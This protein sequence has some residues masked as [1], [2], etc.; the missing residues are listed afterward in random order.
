M[1]SLKLGLIRQDVRTNQVAPY[2]FDNLP[3]FFLFFPASFL[4]A[5]KQRMWMSALI[6][7]REGGGGARGAENVVD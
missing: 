5:S 6:G 3:L 2:L 1:M 4:S 7:E